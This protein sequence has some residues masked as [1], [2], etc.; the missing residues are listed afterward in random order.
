MPGP[1]LRTKPSPVR[2][3]PLVASDAQMGDKKRI[4]A[5]IP[6][7]VSDVTDGQKL[8]PRPRSMRVRSVLVLKRW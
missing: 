5:A 7:V 4:A 3:T 8:T 2:S 1:F 6:F